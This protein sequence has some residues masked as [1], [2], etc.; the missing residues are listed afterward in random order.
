MSTVIEETGVAES[1]IR[2]RYTDEEKANALVLLDANCGQY[3]MT[4]HQLALPISTLYWWDQGRG[5]KP[6]VAELRKIKK[7][8]LAEKLDHV[9]MLAASLAPEKL[10]T[11]SFKDTLIGTGIAIEKAALLR[12]EATQVTEH[13]ITVAVTATYNRLIELGR[14]ED[15]AKRIVAHRFQLAPAQ[16]EELGRE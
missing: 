14:P 10:A 5:V 3:S 2:F 8:E 13:K 7:L 15:E 9:A 16:V 12:G 11:A 1:Y 4:A 6:A